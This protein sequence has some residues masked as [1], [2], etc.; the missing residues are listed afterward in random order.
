MR[1]LLLLFLASGLPLAAGCS[2]E[3]TVCPSVLALVTTNLA[4]QT[5]QPL[6]GLS[7]RDTVRRT[8]AV[9]PV[10]ANSSALLPVDSTRLVPIFPDT[11]GGTL[12]A[13]GDEVI[14]VITAD[15]RL[16]SGVYRLAF[17]GCFVQRLAGPDTLVLR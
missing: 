6:T 12:A 14:V 1:Y 2:T 13:A 11:L 4:N 15:G 3:P 5:G 16:A 17:N 8:G 10:F 7:V 9:L